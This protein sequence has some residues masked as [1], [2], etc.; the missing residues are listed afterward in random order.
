MEATATHHHAD[1][2]DI[3]NDTAAVKI[4]K[5]VLDGSLH[6]QEGRWELAGLLYHSEVIPKT[7]A[8]LCPGTRHRQ[9]TAIDI[10][11]DTLQAKIAGPNPALDLS[12]IA[13]GSSFSGWARRFAC[14]AQ[15]AQTVKRQVWRNSV[16]TQP[17]S[18]ELM[19][20]L[21]PSG[22]ASSSVLSDTVE[23][24]ELASRYADMSYGLV[25]PELE[26]LRAR[27]LADAYHVP[28]PH[29]GVDIHNAYQL[30]R[31]L[32]GS[33]SC[34]KDDITETLEN[35][36]A[37]ARGLSVLWDRHPETVLYALIELPTIVLQAFAEH[38][39][40]PTPSP[41][42][43]HL[44]T[45]RDWLTPILGGK[46]IAGSIARLY[47]LVSS[48]A[49]HRWRDYHG[50][51]APRLRPRVERRSEQDQWDAAV[52]AMVAKGVTSLGRTPK[53]VQDRLTIV[54]AAIVAGEPLPG[55]A[56]RPAA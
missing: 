38:A 43:K 47:A 1:P 15:M 6:E 2:K 51:S 17:A 49:D 21:H 22:E 50:P 42:V 32:L 30:R 11:S 25:D 44:D 55:Y 54:L 53:E 41:P 33:N 3:A 24:D 35:F 20:T 46:H 45:L 28:L 9:S 48:E 16:R 39:L 34:V 26:P 37:G 23:Y 52:T 14:S 8:G 29:R 7:A 5:R 56:L 27:L 36:G 13:N 19:D 18:H 10:I 40:T 4:A 31:R 12:I